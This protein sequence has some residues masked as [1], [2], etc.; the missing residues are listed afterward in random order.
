[1]AS[2]LTAFVL[3]A[4]AT[5]T[6]VCAIAG[7]A[8]TAR[9]DGR[10]SAGRYAALQL[11]LDELH[12]ATLKNTLGDSGHFD[13]AQIQFLQRGTGLKDFR[14]DTDATGGAGRELQSVHDGQGRILGW[15]SWEPERGLIRA[16]TWLWGFVGAFAVG[17]AG[18]AVLAAG[19]IL[20]LAHALAT[21]LRRIRTLTSED[22]L[23]GLPNHRVMLERLEQALARRRSGIVVLALIDLDGFREVN[24]TQGRAGG[25]A[26]MI[27]IAERLQSALPEGALFGRFEDDEFAVV[28]TSDDAHAP[29]L[30]AETLRAALSRPIFMEQNWQVSAG[31]GIAQAPADG[32]TAEELSRRAG[33]ALRVAKHEGRGTVRRFEPAIEIEHTER[34]FIRREL[35]AAIAARA[36]E[37]HY[38]PVVAAAGGGIVA[39]EA[40]ARWTHP[41]RGAI[42]PSV[43]IPLAEQSGMMG[44]LG[45]FVLRRALADG[46]RWPNLSIAVN[47]SPLQIR[48]RGLVDL[49]GAV[50]AETGIA[51]SRVVLEVTEGVLIEDPQETLVRLEALRALGVRLALDDFGTGYSSL[52][53]LQR[54]P[55][56]QLKIDRA[57]VASLGT[58]GNAGAIIQSIVTLGHALGMKV[59]AEGVETDEQRVLLR[60]AGCDEMQGFLFAKPRP[61][62]AI[63]KVVARVAGGPAGARQAAGS[64]R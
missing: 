33:L 27:S 2:R 43:F 1:M 47:L 44:Q 54:F 9:E 30:L 32:E 3:I 16:Q 46:A 12:G 59:L 28:M 61:A 24:E 23:T 31:I 26:L 25:D 37:V 22:A 52:S 40:L 13:A 57:F 17:L 35:E 10:L 21:S 56:S 51:P 5:F 42:A 20:R 60:L 45:E 62:E 6:M 14:F 15:F 39:V 38:Q 50:M 29:A 34:L 11:A 8:V 36:L 55:F 48:D 64:E 58:T 49:V 18:C 41:T 7:Y 4:L 53:Y 63:D 19:S